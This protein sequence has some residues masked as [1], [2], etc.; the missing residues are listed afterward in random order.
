MKRMKDSNVTGGN[1]ENRMNGGKIEDDT[2]TGRSKVEIQMMPQDNRR[3][4]KGRVLKMNTNKKE[5]HLKCK[6]TK[7]AEKA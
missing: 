3:S 6:E 7:V 2:T 1:L 4:R 5:K